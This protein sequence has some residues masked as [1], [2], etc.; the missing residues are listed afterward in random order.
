M[1]LGSTT[2]KKNWKDQKYM[3]FKEHQELMGQP[4]NLRIKKKKNK[5]MD[6]LIM[7]TLWFKKTKQRKPCAPKPLECTK[8]SPQWE[9]SKNISV[10]QDARKFSVRNLILQLKK[11]EEQQQMNHKA[12]RREI[13]KIRADINE[14]QTS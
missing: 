5:S 8:C 13:I 7:K 4:G 9:V 1:K 3:E 12:S 14:K 2:R 6:Q 11:L 10:P